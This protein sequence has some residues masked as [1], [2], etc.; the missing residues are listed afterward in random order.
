MVSQYSATNATEQWKAWKWIRYIGTKWVNRHH[1]LCLKNVPPWSV[2]VLLYK[3]IL[4]SGNFYSIVTWWQI[5]DRAFQKQPANGVL[6][7]S[8][9]ENMQ[10]IYRRTPMLIKR[11]AQFWFFIRGSATSFSTTF[12][13]W[14]F[15]KNI[16]HVTFC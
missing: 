9:S 15:Q 14:F 1:F 11:Y 7:K 4:K 13:A 2:N 3:L 16:L 6:S 10:Q 12:C 5:F 8:Y